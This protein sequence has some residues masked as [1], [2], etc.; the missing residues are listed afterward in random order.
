MTENITNEVRKSL[1]KLET[2]TSMLMQ[3][4]NKM[5]HSPCSSIF[6][7]FVSNIAH[8]GKIARAVIVG[9]TVCFFEL[10][11]FSDT[12]FSCEDLKKTRREEA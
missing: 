3:F 7:H 10:C 5:M 9:F 11:Q 6:L 8:F 2:D 12:F 1:T 4:S